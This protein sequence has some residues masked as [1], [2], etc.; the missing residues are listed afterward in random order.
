M[1]TADLFLTP[2]KFTHGFWN[3]IR[4]VSG[5]AHHIARLRA[6]SRERSTEKKIAQLL[7][8]DRMTDSLEREISTRVQT[9]NWL[10]NR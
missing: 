4:A 6:K 5:F 10:P 2:R 7:G 1:T 8:G 3:P 9:D